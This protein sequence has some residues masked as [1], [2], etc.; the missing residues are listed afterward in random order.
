M[1]LEVSHRTERRTH[2][3]AVATGHTRVSSLSPQRRPT[4]GGCKAPPRPL[5]WAVA[6]R[7]GGDSAEAVSPHAT[8]PVFLEWVAQSF[9]LLIH[10]EA[11]VKSRRN[12]NSSRAW[13]VLARSS[14]NDAPTRFGPA[15]PVQQGEGALCPYTDRSVSRPSGML[16]A[17]DLGGAREC[18]AHAVGFFAL[19]LAHVPHHPLLALQVHSPLC[20]LHTGVA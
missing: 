10:G 1:S 19:A 13:S 11:R 4:S 8:L 7:L 9:Q 16:Q 2:P 20:T 17:G 18:C 14:S 5:S 6:T 15:W 3:P 12:S